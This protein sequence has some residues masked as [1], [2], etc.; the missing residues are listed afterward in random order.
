LLASSAP[1]E[2][3][4]LDDAPA[5]TAYTE[6]I[7]GCVGAFWTSLV[8]RH[9]ARIVEGE[10]PAL[11]SAARRYGRALQLVNVLR[12]VGPDLARGLC[13]LPRDELARA[14]L[15]PDELARAVREPR[16]RA[17]AR[18]RLAPLLHRWARRSRRGLLGGLAYTARLDRA[19]WRVRTATALPA[20]LGLA[21]LGRLPVDP[22]WLDPGAKASIGRSG[23]R[24]VTALTALASL[25]RRGPRGLGRIG[26]RNNGTGSA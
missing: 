10:R 25:S 4:S 26:R 16:G 13:L 7:A 23:L 20:S 19:G 11:E 24:R 2:I 8:A 12:D 9:A 21:T 18:D 15:A 6:G 3:A 5:L 22:A 1:G 17:D 14:G